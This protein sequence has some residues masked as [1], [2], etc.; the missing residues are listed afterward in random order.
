M[1]YAALYKGTNPII[2]LAAGS[3]GGSPWV[4]NPAWLT[5]PV[6]GVSD[7]RMVGLLAITNDDS[8]YIALSCTGDYTVDWGDGVTENFASG[9]IA[10]H[11]YT[12]SSISESTEYT[13]TTGIVARQVIVSV[14]P[15]AGSNLTTVDFQKKHTRTNLQIYNSNWLDIAVNS[16]NMTSLVLGHPTTNVVNL[17]WVQKVNV[18]VVGT[19]TSFNFRAFRLLRSVIISNT[20]NFTSTANMFASC[21]S[22]Q[23]VPLFNTA[24]VT[25]M[26]AMFSFCNS[27]LSVPLFNTGA[28]TDMRNMFA[29]CRSIQWVPLFNTANVTN[30][31]TM[32]LNCYSLQSVPLFNTS[33]V[34]N[35]GGMFNF[36][37]SLQSVPLF[38]TA[39]VTLMFDMFVSCNS[40][41]SVPL[42]N[43]SSVTNMGNMFRGCVSLQTVPLFN[44]A[45]VT[46][47]N[48]I[49]HTCISLVSVPSFNTQSVTL[50]ADPFNSCNSLASAAFSGTKVSHT[51]SFCKLG[52]AAIVDIFTNLG[53]ANSGAYISIF[54]THGAADLTDED[55]LIA[56][57]KGWEIQS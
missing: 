20:I 47:M 44:T 25:D 3:G 24:A 8:N 33:S 32:F 38:N 49:F 51:F 52:R 4:R 5:L 40:L 13:V 36:C 31:L 43:T 15:Q 16:P 18:G 23:S 26:N 22:I 7:Q 17:G 37:N 55:R 53:T 14:I 35:M 27:L 57:N 9:V 54:G 19:V 48:T 10:E 1:S 12:Y 41:Q 2:R 6:L 45:S 21:N 28:V 56:T 50:L 11:L 30:M 42:F 29:N 34:T 46:N 39:N